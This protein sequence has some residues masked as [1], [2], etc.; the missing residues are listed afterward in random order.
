MNNR[1]IRCAGMLLLLA[2]AASFSGC[3]LYREDRCWVPEDQY[4]DARQ[5]YITTG[6]LDLVIQQLE[7]MQ[8]RRCKINEIR[9]RLEKEFEVL[10][11]ERPQMTHVDPVEITPGEAGHRH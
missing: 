11:E 9:Y 7:E 8:W 2:G 5:L 1:I 4:L 3:A 10:P 6:S